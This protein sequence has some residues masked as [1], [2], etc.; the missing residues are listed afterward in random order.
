MKS[1]VP[2]NVLRSLI[3]ATG[4]VAMTV[5]FFRWLLPFL[6]PFVVGWLLSLLFCPAAAFLQNRLHCP[7]WL[8]A[9]AAMAIFFVL[10][11]ILGVHLW[12]RLH[13]EASQLRQSLPACLCACRAAAQKWDLWVERF[14][15]RLP[16]N[17]R[18]SSALRSAALMEALG[19][20]LLSGPVSFRS[21]RVL[22]RLP[23]FL[24][25][26]LFALLSAYYFTADAPAMGVF[27]RQHPLLTK[28]PRCRLAMG[29]LRRALGGYFKA[30]LILMVYVF[31]VC[32]TGFLVL[33]SPYAFL[34]ALLTAAIDALP[35]FGSG[36]VLWPG[37]LISLLSGRPALAFGYLSIYLAVCFVRQILQPRL[38][39]VQIG[40]HP[41]VC[42]LSMY[43]GWKWI[44]VPGFFA[45]P[46]AAVVLKVILRAQCSPDKP[47]FPDL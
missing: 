21:V 47:F 3:W 28:N 18:F 34:L 9:L 37:A 24:L 13:T 45:G 19:K 42:L 14:S 8:G 11:G 2:E 43:L 15:L 17:W 20:W 33:G 25:S 5:V 6:A 7:R 22:L 35:F 46:V 31:G 38:L 30:Q 23:A 4:V 32:L 12:T 16:E 29:S 44:G 26:S 39:R 10:L 41:L 40:I 36:V 27:F 1:P